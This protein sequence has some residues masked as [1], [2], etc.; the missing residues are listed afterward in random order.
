MTKPS[1][2]MLIADDECNIRNNRSVNLEAAGQR[3]RY[4]RQAWSALLLVFFS[5]SP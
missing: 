5:L 1:P 4:T 3:H 2:R